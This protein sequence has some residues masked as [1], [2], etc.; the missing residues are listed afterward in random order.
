M[1]RKA[2]AMTVAALGFVVSPAFAYE[3]GAVSDGGT[4]SGTVKFQGA[5]PARKELEVTKDKE[6]CGK[7]QKMSRDL[8]V[9]SGGGLQ[10]AVVSITNIQKGKADN[11][12]VV[13]LDQNG[14]EY[15]PHII[16]VPVGKPFEIKNSDGIN[17][18]IHAFGKA[19]TEWNKAT[20]GFFTKQNKTLQ[21]TFDKPEYV[22]VGCDVHSW[23]TGWFVVKDNPYYE[24]TDENGS[25]KMTDVPPGEYEVKVWHE[26]LGEKTTKVTVAAKG[27]A[28]ADF[29]LAPK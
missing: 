8:V 18:N 29:E 22:R 5:P 27:E 21:M 26:K 4:I 9:S 19:N 7:T 16:V 15:Q 12:A 2:V 1:N 25:Y 13:V 28:K 3:G 14:C 20:P 6:V 23:M 10:Y 24:V 17:H 11:G